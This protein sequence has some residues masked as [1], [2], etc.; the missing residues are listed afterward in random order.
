MCMICGGKIEDGRA[1]PSDGVAFSCATHGRYAVA[2]SALPRFLQL[3]ADAQAAAVE[4]AKLF[5]A[6]RNGEVVV[7]SLDL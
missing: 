2:R 7:T 4:R 1:T 5:A 3:S 6:G